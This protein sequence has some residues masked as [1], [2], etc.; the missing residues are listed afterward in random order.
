MTNNCNAIEVKI[1]TTSHLFLNG[2]SP[3]TDLVVDLNVIAFTI[4]NIIKE[5]NAI[6]LA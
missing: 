4:W 3:N 6:V 5:E 1:A 2:F